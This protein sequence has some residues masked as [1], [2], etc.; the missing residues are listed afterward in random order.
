MAKFILSVGDG[1]FK[2]LESEAKRRDVTVQQLLR[3][4]IVPEWVRENLELDRPSMPSREIAPHLMHQSI[5]P[6]QR[7]A[8]LQ[9]PVNRL[10]P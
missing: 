5:Y 8:M 4:V 2:I 6:G 10:R 7:D 1:T 3:A 9:A